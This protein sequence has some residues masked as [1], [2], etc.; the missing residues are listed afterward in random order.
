ARVRSPK[1]SLS[2]S[3]KMASSPAMARVWCRPIERL[4]QRHETDTEVIEFLKSG[5][6]F[7]HRPSP[8]IEAPDQHDVDLPP[9][10]GCRQPLRLGASNSTNAGGGGLRR[11]SAHPG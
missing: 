4:G 5:Q 1:D 10:G 9:T 2:N 8:A 11:V 7:R 6:P 3:A